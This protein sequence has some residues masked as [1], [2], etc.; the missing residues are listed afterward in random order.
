MSRYFLWPNTP[1]GQLQF[2]VDMVNTV[3]KGPHGAGVFYW[4]PER[5]IWNA[6]GSPGPAVFT[7]DNLTRLT[8]RPESHVPV[9]IKP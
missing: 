7:P 1:E 9:E 6:D 8:Q 3:R 5:A 4:A 2:M